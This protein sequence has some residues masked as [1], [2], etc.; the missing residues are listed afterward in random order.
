MYRVQ[1]L[2][3]GQPLVVNPKD[4]M[5]DSSQVSYEIPLPDCFTVISDGHGKAMP[6]S[7]ASGT[8][9]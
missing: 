8:P 7:R 2:S 1:S 3:A 4:A 5:A 6:P 9:Y